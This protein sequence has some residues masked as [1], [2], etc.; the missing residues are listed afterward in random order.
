MYTKEQ[1]KNID[2]ELQEVKKENLYFHCHFFDDFFSFDNNITFKN[3]DIQSY[4]NGVFNFRFQHKRLGSYYG[5]EV[6]VS[7][8]DNLKN[9]SKATIN[10]NI[11]PYTYDNGNFFNKEK[12]NITKLS[13]IEK[14]FIGELLSFVSDLFLELDFDNLIS[15]LEIYNEKMKR[16]NQLLRQYVRYKYDLNL[17]ENRKTY[18]KQFSLLTKKRT[19]DEVPSEGHLSFCYLSYKDS[20]FGDRFE[21][22]S[23]NISIKEDGFYNGNVKIDEHTFLRHFLNDSI[24]LKNRFI[25]NIKEF[26]D[27]LN[28]VDKDDVKIISFSLED[29]NNTF[30]KEIIKDKMEIF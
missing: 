16:K 1:L 18:H 6:E 15:K 5:I 20:S 2:K 11:T 27:I 10:P 9:L 14:K 4:S 19:R 24:Y 3:L 23:M 21:I 7:F 30:S 29:F 8:K 28:F 13:L 17:Q 25:S 22:N 12:I 26:C